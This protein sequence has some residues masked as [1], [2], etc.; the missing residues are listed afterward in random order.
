MS[1]SA[2]SQSNATPDRGN[3]PL[4]PTTGAEPPALTDDDQVPSAPNLLDEATNKTS[5]T[6]QLEDLMAEALSSPEEYGALP[7]LPT[8]LAIRRPKKH[9]WFR[10]HPDFKPAFHI[11]QAPA[12]DRRD[13]IYLVRKGAAPIFGDA[14]K[15]ATLRLCV[16]SEGVPFVWIHPHAEGGPGESWAK[17]RNEVAAAAIKGWVKITAGDGC[18]N[19]ERPLRPEVFVEPKWPE[20]THNDWLLRTFLQ[21]MIVGDHKHPAAEYHRGQRPTL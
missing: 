19:I 17:S 15:P 16:N 7:A 2:N 4:A 13:R 1:D 14:A 21:D 20:G 5:A 3:G 6:A 18:Y 9:E 10:I 8:Q 11:Y 12:K